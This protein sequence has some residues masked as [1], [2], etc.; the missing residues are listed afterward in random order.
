MQRL[1]WK[2]AFERYLGTFCE[3]DIL[4]K[5]I[6]V[7]P[8]K[9]IFNEVFKANLTQFWWGNLD[10]LERSINFAGGQ[11]WRVIDFRH[12]KRQDLRFDLNLTSIWHSF[13]NKTK[14]RKIFD[15]LICRFAGHRSR[16][17]RLRATAEKILNDDKALLVKSSWPIPKA[18][19]RRLRLSS[20]MSRIMSNVSTLVTK[21]R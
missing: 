6:D 3:I 21:S 10:C 7:F 17:W 15:Q 13:E 1:L 11:K 9:L 8:S 18:G 19:K 4:F 14:P 12:F 5:T 16:K 20:M 2:Y